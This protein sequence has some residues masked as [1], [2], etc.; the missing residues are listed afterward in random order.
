MSNG[1]DE[2]VLGW[3]RGGEVRGFAVCGQ[4]LDNGTFSGNAY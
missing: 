1:Q 3:G 2:Q 4:K